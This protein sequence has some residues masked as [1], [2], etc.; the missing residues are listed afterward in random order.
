[1]R[2]S[3]YDHCLLT[4]IDTLYSGICHESQHPIDN[5]KFKFR[6]NGEGYIL[7]EEGEYHIFALI[8]VIS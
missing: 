2:N 6:V 3:S 7:Y 1:M 5:L 8:I 4:F